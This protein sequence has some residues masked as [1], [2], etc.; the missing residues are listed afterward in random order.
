MALQLKNKAKEEKTESEKGK[1]G[2]YKRKRNVF[3]KRLTRFGLIG[4]TIGLVAAFVIIKVVFTLSQ[5]AKQKRIDKKLSEVKALIDETRRKLAQKQDSYDNVGKL[6]STLPTTFDRQ[7]LSIDLNRMVV[8]AELEEN[9]DLNKRKIVELEKFP[10]EEFPVDTV[11]A[12]QIEMTLYGDLY[13]YEN[14]LNFINYL[15]EYNHENFYY[16]ESIDYKEDVIYY[17]STTKITMY[18]FYNDVT[19]NPVVPNGTTT[20]TA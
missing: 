16:I 8:L 14:I 12:V 9:D 10:F 1:K 13:H 20:T 4:L 3:G 2:K 15:T 5:N 17:R 11:K 6:I 18:T 19:L 7:A